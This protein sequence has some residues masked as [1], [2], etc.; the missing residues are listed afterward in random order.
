[1]KL[2]VYIQAA[3][4]LIGY[5]RCELIHAVRKKMSSGNDKVLFGLIYYMMPV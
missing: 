2:S 1:M 5:M 4:G 3:V